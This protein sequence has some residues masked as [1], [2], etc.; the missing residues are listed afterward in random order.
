MVTGGKERTKS[1]KLRR[2]REK[3]R[4]LHQQSDQNNSKQFPQLLVKT[5]TGIS[6]LK[7]KVTPRYTKKIRDNINE[8]EIINNEGRKTNENQVER[9]EKEKRITLLHP[10]KKK[11]FTSTDVN[12]QER[13]DESNIG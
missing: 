10:I 1:I 3:E 4:E 13:S 6:L 9:E 2:E 5:T 11:N 8:I 12:I 7:T